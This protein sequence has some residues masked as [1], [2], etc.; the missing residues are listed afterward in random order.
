MLG[1]Y[2]LMIF[3]LLISLGLPLQGKTIEGLNENKC[4]FYLSACA[5]FQDEAP[6]LK[7]WIEFHQLM[8]VEHFYLYNNNSHDDF[9]EVLDP[10][11]QAGIIELTNWPSPEEED[12]T[13]YQQQAYNHCIQHCTGKTRWLAVLDI[14]EFMFPVEASNLKD[15]LQPY[16]CDTSIGGVKLFWQVY[17]T[18]GVDKIAENELLIEKLTMKAVWNHPW[19]HHVKTICKPHKVSIFQVHRAWYKKG[20]KDIM[21]NGQEGPNRPIQLNRARINHYWTRDEHFFYNVKIPR[22]ERLEKTHYS[23]NKIN[24]YINC[25]NKTPDLA[26]YRFIPQLKERMLHP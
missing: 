17:G 20:Y 15:F 6:Y 23:Q 1:K 5:I 7:E 11:L 3:F 26:I 2:T 12:W 10:Y 21:T 22:R 25:F 24:D 19:N 8:G 18:S 14:D 16:D 9:I 4:D 13:P